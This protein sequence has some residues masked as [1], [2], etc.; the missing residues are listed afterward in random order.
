L[1]EGSQYGV[2]ILRGPG[3]T[4]SGTI[5]AKYAAFLNTGTYADNQGLLQGKIGLDVY[6]TAGTIINSGTI[7]GTT[8][9]SGVILTAGSTRSNSGIISSVSGAGVSFGGSISA[10]LGGTLIDSGTINGGSGAA[11]D[12]AGTGGSLL[13]LGEWL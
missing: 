3:V 2:F 12:F 10:F 13:V 11:I 7:A 9:G 4:N 1:I 6:A 8:S 5:K